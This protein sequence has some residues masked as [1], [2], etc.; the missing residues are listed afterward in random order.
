MVQKEIYFVYT[1]IFCVRDI[2]LIFVWGGGVYEA[3]RRG[4][5]RYME[6]T[7]GG[8]GGENKARNETPILGSFKFNCLVP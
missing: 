8:G 4:G 1:L 7:I 3:R 6:P 2:F 5:I